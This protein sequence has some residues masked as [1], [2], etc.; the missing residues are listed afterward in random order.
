MDQEVS[1]G[2]DDHLKNYT[3]FIVSPISCRRLG[4]FLSF[5]DAGIGKHAYFH[6]YPR[7]ESLGL[8]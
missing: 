8:F 3:M 1:V 2:S 7:D 5:E 4:F 6:G